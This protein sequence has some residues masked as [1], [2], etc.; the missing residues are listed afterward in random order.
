M[1]P[2]TAAASSNVCRISMIG[3]L[4]C[5]PFGTGLRA[6]RACVELTPIPNIVQLAACRV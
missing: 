2:S 3:L 4:S 1:M 5:N 6:A